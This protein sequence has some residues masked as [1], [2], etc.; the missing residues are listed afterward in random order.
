[1][2]VSLVFPNVGKHIH[3]ETFEPLGILYIAA[4]ISEGHSVQIVDAFNRKL[5]V[6]ETVRELLAFGPDVVGISLTMSP[7]TPFVKNLAQRIRETLWSFVIVGGTHA[8]FM[9]DDLATTPDIDVVVLHEGE[10]TFRELLDYREGRKRLCDIRGIVYQHDNKTVKTDGRP[11]IKDLDGLPFPARQFLPETAIYKRKHI[12]SSRGCVFRCIYCASSAMNQYQWRPRSPDNVIREIESVSAE[13]SHTFYFADDNF[14]VNEDR[15]ISICKGIVEKN[16]DVHWGCLSRIEFIDNPDL[17][18]NMY[19][20]G[21]NQIFIGAESGSDAILKKMKRNY[22][23]ADVKR[24]VELCNHKGI[25]TTVSFIIGSPYETKEDIQKTLDLAADLDT[26]NVAFH[27]FTPYVGT[28]AYVNP[29]KYGIT[30]LSPN[31]EQFDKNTRPVIKTRYLK[32]EEIMEWYCESF[33]V[34]II[35]GRQGWWKA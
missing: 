13:Y 17:L 26:P 12:L 16:L 2:K 10:Y 19:E 33:G 5:D 21:C 4:M 35:K 18:D 7:T 22:T 8:T 9:A 14:P 31:P 23:A 25:S 1:M 3:E 24:I 20:G 29:E 27:I 34:S 11:P 28:P 15:T 32:P 6:Q 30:I